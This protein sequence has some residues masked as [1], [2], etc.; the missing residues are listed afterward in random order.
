MKRDIITDTTVNFI[1]ANESNLKLAFQVEKALLVVRAELFLER[2]EKQLKETVEA[3][4][5]WEIKATDAEG[6]WMRKK[7][8]DQLKVGED[9]RGWWGICLEL[10]DGGYPCISVTNIERTT[11]NVKKQISSAF[12]NSL[13]EPE[14][15]EQYIWVY[16]KDDIE[17]FLEKMKDEEEQQKI[18]KDMTDKLAKLAVAVDGV[19]SNSR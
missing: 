13:G 3:T 8:W 15:D 10:D 9:S 1:R 5:G 17:S 19:L 14:T 12:P 16:L 2:V 6:L 4:E 18:I 11:E 7:S